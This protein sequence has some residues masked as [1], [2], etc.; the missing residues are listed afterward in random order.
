MN[1]WKRHIVLFGNASRLSTL[2][3]APGVQPD[4][5]CNSICCAY[6][7]FV[8][9]QE[10]NQIT[11][12]TQCAVLINPVYCTRSAT[13][14]LVQLNMLCLSP[15]YCTKLLTGK[16]LGCYQI[17]EQL[18][19]ITNCELSARPEAEARL[20]S[21]INSSQAPGPFLLIP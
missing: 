1:V 21:S 9:H 14:S 7:P 19:I 16:S 4:H 2:C 12:A 17:I 20:L 13:R 6:Q 8:L 5:L 10:C 15:V 3:T 11:C 18:L